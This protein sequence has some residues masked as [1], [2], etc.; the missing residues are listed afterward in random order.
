[1]PQNITYYCL[2]RGYECFEDYIDSLG[3]ITTKVYY[4]KDHEL[5]KYNFNEGVHIFRYNIP[6]FLKV[7]K[8]V[9]V[10]NTEQMS[11]SARYSHIAEIINKGF[12]IIDYS[13]VNIGILR[14]QFP[15]SKFYYLPYQWSDAEVTKFCGYSK[16]PKLD[17]GI[18]SCTT[19]HR[20]K[21]LTQLQ[22][23]GITAVD[24]RGWK[25]DRDKIIGNCKIL[26]NVHVKHDF[27]IYE[28]IRCDRWTFAGKMI[29]SE[30]SKDQEKLDI[31]GHVVFTPNIVETIKLLINKKFTLPPVSQNI[32]KRR[33]RYL[34]EFIDQCTTCEDKELCSG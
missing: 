14:K 9:Y 32:K 33:A 11:E 4:D 23:A 18:V 3:I 15:N 13:I 17:V 30:Y 10:L 27:T 1:M 28:H 19:P 29:V 31:Y 8:Q 2:R 24:V 6:G 20:R 26:L 5:S 34:Q 12:S 22:A 16:N 21:I 25:D 7:S